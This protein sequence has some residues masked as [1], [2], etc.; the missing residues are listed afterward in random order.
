MK[1]DNL[2]GLEFFIEKYAGSLNREAIIK[3]DILRQ[4]ISFDKINEK[5]NF[6]SKSYFIFSFNV[7]NDDD[8]INQR[9]P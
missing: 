2:T 3:E 6:S 4:G 5:E 8:I 7:D 9:Y 1:K